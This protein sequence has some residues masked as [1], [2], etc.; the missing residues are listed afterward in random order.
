[1]FL[2]DQR[3]LHIWLT[4]RWVLLA[5]GEFSSSNRPLPYALS[6]VILPPKPLL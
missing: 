3:A 4:V 5:A 6:Y 2:S 1:M